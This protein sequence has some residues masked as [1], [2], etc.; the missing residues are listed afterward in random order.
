MAN[1][2]Q[3]VERMMTGNLPVDGCYVLFRDKAGNPRRKRFTSGGSKKTRAHHD[4]DRLDRADES[5]GRNTWKKVER[6]HQI[7]EERIRLI[8]ASRREWR[9]AIRHQPML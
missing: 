2:C 6:V 7:S 8:S 9:G 4:G 1:K 5:A 3:F